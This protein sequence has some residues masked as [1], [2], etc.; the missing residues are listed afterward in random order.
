M[1]RAGINSYAHLP[2]TTTVDFYVDSGSGEWLIP[3]CDHSILSK[4]LSPCQ[5]SLMTDAASKHNAKD[6]IAVGYLSEREKNIFS[7]L[8]MRKLEVSF[9]EGH[10]GTCGSEADVHA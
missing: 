3:K 9:T 5:G 2:L 1:Q 6:S 4:W 10:S 7:D 8:G